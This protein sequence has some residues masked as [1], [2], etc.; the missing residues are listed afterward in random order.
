MRTNFVFV[1]DTNRNMLDPCH[2]AVARKLMRQGRAREF[3][4][5]PEVIILDKHVPD[6][7]P[8]PLTLKIDPGSNVTGFA[9][10]TAQGQVVWAAEL[11][12][13]GQAISASLTS[14]AQVRR[15]RRQRTTRYRKARFHYRTKEKGWLAPSLLHRVLTIASWVKRLCSYAYI[16]QIAME[17]VKFDTQAMQNPEISGIEYQQGTLAGYE[18]REYLLEK[19]G[20]RCAYCAA[21]N[22]PFQVEHIVPTSKGGSDRVSNLAL[23][24]EPCNR[25]KGTLPVQ[26]FLAGKPD[27]VK[28]VLAQA[29]A[30]LR[31]AAAVNAT[32]WALFTTLKGTGLPVRT[33]SGGQT[34]YN[35]C[36]L[37]FP[38]THW[39]DAACVGESSH[40][41][42]LTT[43]PLHIKATGHG[44]RQMCRTDKYGVP[45]RHVPR[46]KGVK[47]VQTGDIVKAVVTTGKK[48]GIYVGRVAVRS[49]GYFNIATGGGLVQG[50]SHRYCTIIHK[51][52]GYRYAF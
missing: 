30:P 23:A 52:D 27:V 31:D 36:R 10:L 33:G 20:R 16:T 39:L 2:P 1:L 11:T 42:L 15:S 3:R 26:V 17:L 47:G 37:G 13:R 29:Q 4:R 46:L 25:A 35:R 32:R 22:T 49:T 6:A 9:L 5:Y 34:K 21:E 43:Q 50:I 38:K 14:R 7:Q 24:C 41:Q 48:I 40:V 44:T 45:R 51:K 28:R 12:H 19:W 8:Q 18:V